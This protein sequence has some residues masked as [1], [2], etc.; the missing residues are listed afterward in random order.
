MHSFSLEK[1]T[2]KKT[3]TITVGMQQ[4]QGVTLTC[5]KNTRA[6]VK[7]EREQDQ[8]TKLH[9]ARPGVAFPG[10]VGVRIG[11][12]FRLSRL[13]DSHDRIQKSLEN[14]AKT[15]FFGVFRVS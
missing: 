7:G 1:K 6:F 12:I 14:R 9:P 4:L 13:S 2:I 8:L 5:G 10:P 11:G 3:G 15:L